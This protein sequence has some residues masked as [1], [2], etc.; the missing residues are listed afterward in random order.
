MSESGGS[1]WDQDPSKID[2]S[3]LPS[4]AVGEVL[5]IYA[6][7]AKKYGRGNYQKGIHYSRVFSAAMRHLWAWWRGEEVD[8][9]SG[10]SHLAHAAW[11]VITL[12]E[13]TQSFKYQP[14]DDRVIE[15]C[16]PIDFPADLKC[17]HEWVYS[18]SYGDTT[19]LHTKYN[20][21]KCGVYR[22]EHEP[23]TF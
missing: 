1:K 12:L 10:L 20:C 14:F 16:A 15:D 6:G 3:Y 22:E 9:E 11:N 8:Q 5:K 18:T 21:K 7:G 4:G 13:Y 17:E 23:P 2:W 19:G